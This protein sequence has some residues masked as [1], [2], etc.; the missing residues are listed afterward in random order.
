GGNGSDSQSTFS[1]RAAPGLL[2]R[3]EFRE[4][5]STTAEA[6]WP[7]EIALSTS[8]GVSGSC[9]AGQQHPS[10]SSPRSRSRN[11]RQ[12][13]LV[14][15]GIATHGPC[16]SFGALAAESLWVTRHAWTL[17]PGG[18]VTASG[19]S[20]GYW[21]RTQANSNPWKTPTCSFP[22]FILSANTWQSGTTSTSP[23]SP[24]CFWNRSEN[25]RA[26]AW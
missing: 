8:S 5:T 13:A 3:Y 17:R 20:S 26:A 16:R 10:G 2:V 12:W 25:G 19:T 22:S 6:S 15:R 23:L 24:V 18:M 1:C 4:D 7:C 9:L 14:N 21:S 11:S